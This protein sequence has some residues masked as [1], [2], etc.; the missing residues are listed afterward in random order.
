MSDGCFRFAIVNM[1]LAEYDQ[2][3]GGVEKCSLRRQEFDL[4]FFSTE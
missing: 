1:V 2:A 4:R 3:V